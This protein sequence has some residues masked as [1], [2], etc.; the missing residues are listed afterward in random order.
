MEGRWED[1][2]VGK[3]SPEITAA[4]DLLVCC[5]FNNRSGIKLFV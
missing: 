2:W 5:G 4:D 1:R 3:F